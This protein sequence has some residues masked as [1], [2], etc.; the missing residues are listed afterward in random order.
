[1]AIR[2]RVGKKGTT[3]TIDYLDPTGKRIRQ[4]FK[5]KKD[6][7]GEHDKIKTLIREKRFLDIKKEYT[8]TLGELAAKYKEN[9]SS[10]SFYQGSKHRYIKNFIDHFG[11][12]TVLGLVRYMDLE[13][14][15]NQLRAKPTR[16]G[17]IRADASVNREM[18]TLHHLFSKAVQWEMMEQNPFDRGRTLKLKENNTRIRYLEEGEIQR[19][20]EEC[21]PKKHLHRIV[22]CALH[23]G[24]RRGE[25]LSLKWEQIRNGFIYLEKTKTKE[26]REIPINEDLAEV[27]KEIRRE[28]GLSSPYVFTYAK[29]TIQVIYTGFNAAV[30][31]AGIEDFRF[32]DLRHTFASHLVMRGASLKEVQ[33]LLGHKNI[34]MTM[35]YAHLGED[36]KRKAVS[37]LNGLSG[38][39][40][41]VTKC[42]KFEKLVCNSL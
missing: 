12:N 22:T 26:R 38:K 35:R 33:E 25:I 28:Q 4:T 2:K 15:Q 37:L 27:L 8:A 42:H 24:M 3:W 20:L 41:N 40:G 11:K 9:F 32:H 18:V 17:K 21:Q 29:R 34:A 23:T 10:Q 6:A 14:Y 39:K 16:H 31:R 13:T 5:K 30:K 1:M 7:D 36:Q 19:L